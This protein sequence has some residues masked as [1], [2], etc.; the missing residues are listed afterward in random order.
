VN[1]GAFDRLI[2]VQRGAAVGEDNYGGET[3]TWD[4]T[5]Q[6]YARVRFGLAAEKRMA[7][8]EGGVQT[9]TFEVRPT[10]TLLQTNIKDRIVFDGDDWDITEVAPLERNS[11][12]FTAV[13]SRSE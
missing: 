8:Q 4:D 11:L 10:T 5:E 9:A 13:R 3:L 1:R 2:T 12:R 6:A 7:A